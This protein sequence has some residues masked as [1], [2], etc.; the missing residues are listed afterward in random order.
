MQTSNGTTRYAFDNAWDRARQRL[1]HLEMW[2]DPGTIRHLIALDVGPGWRCLE[3]GAGG[4]SI[5]TWL[6]HRVGETGA[7]LATDIN[8]CFVAPLDLANLA[9]FQH[10]ITAGTPARHEFDLAHERL[11]LM[12]L[13]NRQRALQ[14]MVEALKPGGWLLVEE[15]D[16]GSFSA[17]QSCD[18]ATRD[19]F[20]KMAKAHHTVMRAR[21]FNP[22]YGRDLLRDLR[23]VGLD[24]VDA[25]GRVSICEGGSPGAVAWQLTFEQLRNEIVEAGAASYEE[26]AQ[27]V[28]LLD[29]PEV[30]FESQ[31]TM[32]AWGRCPV[33]A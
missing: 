8:P 18:S 23:S 2:L 6:S 20:L 27:F 10:D 25:E 5:A 7:V 22:W 29:D 31:V 14:H 13:P 17:D 30:T 4:G 9:V 24:D 33:A 19:L 1:A 11:V 3:V 26:V 28:T 12:H 15:M 21:G 16:F 32:A